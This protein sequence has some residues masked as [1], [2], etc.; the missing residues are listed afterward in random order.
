MTKG[1]LFSNV[2]DSFFTMKVSIQ[3]YLSGITKPI[4]D[5]NILL[6][7]QFPRN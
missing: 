6:I 4:Y 1:K 7:F 5:T 2:I 3:R